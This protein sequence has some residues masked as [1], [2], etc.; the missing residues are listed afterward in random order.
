M[1]KTKFANQ[2]ALDEAFGTQDD[3]ETN[4]VQTGTW[5]PSEVSADD[6]L[7]WD[8]QSSEPDTTDTTD[9]TTPDAIPADGTDT[10]SVSDET[11][12]SGD[13]ATTED[14]P[15]EEV[16]ETPAEASEEA[17]D[18][19]KILQDLLSEVE[20]KDTA[21]L[22][23]DKEIQATVEGSSMPDAEKQDLLTKL[24]EKDQ[25]VAE[26]DDIISELQT[27][28]KV[29]EDK[30][31]WAITEN[32]NYR[33]E[34]LAN[35]KVLDKIQS[36]PE[37]QQFVS[38]KIRADNWDTAAWDQLDWLLSDIMK[39]RWIDVSALVDSQKKAEK[40]ALSQQSVPSYSQWDIQFD[41]SVEWDALDN[42]G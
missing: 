8:D 30:H 34:S 21:I 1:A 32:E 19:E 31:S 10:T 18:P 28:N 35:K 33:I 40:T 22:E 37:I 7:S 20:N 6:F 29:L 5:T 13:A 3:T 38:L 16:G 2:D 26:K 39:S 24:Q 41:P 12:A 9:T 14:T 15:W 25:I 4:D 42:L 36:D 23:K 11:A 17:E 27:R